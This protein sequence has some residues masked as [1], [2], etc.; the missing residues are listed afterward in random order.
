MPKR[1]VKPR[2]GRL[3]TKVCGEFRNAVAV[4]IST[5][6]EDQASDRLCSRRLPLNKENS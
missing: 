1:L 3:K 6:N 4:N 2:R 5:A